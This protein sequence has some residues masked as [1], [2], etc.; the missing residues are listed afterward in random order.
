[1]TSCVVAPPVRSADETPGMARISG[2]SS[3]RAMAR[4]GR[5]GRAPAAGPTAATMTGWSLMLT[6][7]DARLDALGQVEL[8]ERRLDGGTR[9]LDVGAVL[10]LGDDQGQ[11]VGGRGRKRLQARH[12]LD[13]L[14]DGHGHLQRDVLGAG[15][16]LGRDD[17]HEG[18]LDVRQQLLLQAGPTRQAAEEQRHGR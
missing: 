3:S 18:Q 1:M 13:G 15:A 4:R 12:A 16:R 7:R 14:L 11:R 6:R 10:E 8:A 9:L 2:S 5:P 17:G